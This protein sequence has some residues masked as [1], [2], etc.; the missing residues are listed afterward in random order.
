MTLD[1][2][3]QIAKQR[4]AQKRDRFWREE[5]RRTIREAKRPAWLQRAL[6]ALEGD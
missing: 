4:R 2:A 1:E 3:R 6:G 5:N